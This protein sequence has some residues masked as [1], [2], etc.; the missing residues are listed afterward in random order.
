MSVRVLL[1]DNDARYRLLLAH[2]INT[3]WADASIIEHDPSKKGPLPQDFTAHE[4]DVVL[5]DYSVGGY[6]GLDWLRDFKR[7]PGFPPVIFLTAV[8]DELLAV[9]AIKAGA[10]DYIPKQKIV[11]DYLIN[12]IKEAA[13][14]RKRTSA[15]LEQPSDPSEAKGL[16]RL[17]VG[18]YKFLRRLSEGATSSVYLAE[19]E[20][21][22]ELV[23]LKILRQ[24]PDVPEGKSAFERFIQEYEVISKI[25]HPNIVKIF[26]LGV[27]DDQA[28]IAME[29]FPAGDLKARIVKG[30]TPFDALNY[31]RQMANA[32]H[33]IHSVGVL[34][35]DLKPQNVM[36][37]RDDTLALID[38]GLAK[39]LRL[40]T[41]LTD[42][43]QIFGTPY[44]MS[45]EQGHGE[46]LDERADIYS[47]GVIFYEMLTGEKPYVASAPMGVIYKHSHA[48]I[49]ML[50]KNLL[51]H[52]TVLNRMMAKDRKDRFQS[53]EG[54][55]N[56]LADTS[57]PIYRG[58]GVK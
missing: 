43:G 4:Y 36:L 42:T 11:H 5:L 44:Y 33:A 19:S 47:L 22:G 29:Y 13:R 8:G 54:L 20:P 3:E 1:I 49:P 31:L 24:V 17:S 55:L 39:Q 38:F 40:D 58:A 21:P 41:D 23:V 45:P 25:D 46:T 53:A 51:A 30:I 56:L 28:Y 10:E 12:A 6:S 50:P 34:H 2:H 14:K 37:R 26:D 48:A 9:K 16:G 7:R 32:L 52:Q 18:G 57:L 35:R 15:L 27:A